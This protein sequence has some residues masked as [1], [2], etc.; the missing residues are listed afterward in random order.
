MKRM[1]MCQLTVHDI[2]NILREK[3]ILKAEEYPTVKMTTAGYGELSMSAPD[4]VAIEVKW[5]D[6]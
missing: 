1:L 6:Q 4:T 5:N 3:G 2:V